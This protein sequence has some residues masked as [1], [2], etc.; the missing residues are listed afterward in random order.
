MSVYLFLYTDMILL[1]AEV[2]FMVNTRRK[3]IL[4]LLENSNEI[5]NATAMA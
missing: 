1:C 5:I 2:E 3:K 4:E